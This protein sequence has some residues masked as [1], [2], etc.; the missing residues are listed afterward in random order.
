MSDRLSRPPA[1]PRRM[2]A[3][4]TLPKAPPSLHLITSA[5]RGCTID[6][7]ADTVRRTSA[8]FTDRRCRPRT[9]ARARIRSSRS[10]SADVGGG[11]GAIAMVPVAAGG[12]C[13]R[14]RVSGPVGGAGRCGAGAD[15]GRRQLGRVAAR[16]R[17]TLTLLRG[18]K[19]TPHTPARPAP[20]HHQFANRKLRM[21]PSATTYSFPSRR[22]NPFSFAAA[23]PP[24][25]TKSS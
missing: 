1:G 8:A 5:S 16:R 12:R 11:G 23:D 4:H 10:A 3:P 22:S 21:S 17:R 2:P 9:A 7:S 18:T 14:L 6:G 20:A 19:H 25:R 24:H 13:G 15:A